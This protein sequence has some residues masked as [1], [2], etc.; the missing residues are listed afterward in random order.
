MIENPLLL[1]YLLNAIIKLQV[2]FKIKPLVWILAI[3][4]LFLLKH[5]FPILRFFFYL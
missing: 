3:R 4:V 2:K 1:Y 5:N